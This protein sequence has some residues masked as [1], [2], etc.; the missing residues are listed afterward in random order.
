M[1]GLRAVLVEYVLVMMAT[2]DPIAVI[3]PT[4]TLETLPTIYVKV[5]TLSIFVMCIHNT[6][7]IIP[8]IN[9]LLV[10]DRAL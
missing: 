4:T 6:C 9:N 8:L 5:R 10:N 1:K 7:M 3:V 2:L